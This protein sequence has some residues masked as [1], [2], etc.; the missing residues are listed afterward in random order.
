LQT[1]IKQHFKGDIW[2]WLIAVVGLMM[3]SLPAIYSAS[4]TVA[5]EQEKNYLLAQI[6][7][8]AISLA[9]MYFTHT[10]DYRYYAR[11]SQ[12]ALV[13]AVPLLLYTLFKGDD[14]NEARR[15]ITIPIIKVSFQT[16]DFAKIALIAFVARYL[17]KRQDNIKDFKRTFAPIIFYIGIICLLILPA[18]FST[19]MILFTSCLLLMFIGRV[20]FAQLAALVGVGAVVLAIFFGY[21]IY[22]EKNDLPNFGRLGTWKD[23]V[24]SYAGI[25]KTKNEKESYQTQRANIAIATGGIVGKG[26]GKST[27]RNSLPQAYSDFIYAIIIEEYGLVGGL[28]VMLFYLMF[29]YRV[30]KIVVKAPKAFGALLAV[31]L[32]FNIVFQAVINMAVAVGLFPVTGQTLPFLSV[33]GT[34]LLFTSISVGIILSVSKDIEAQKA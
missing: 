9:A 10:L 24:E 27:Q 18:N 16:S 32:A 19:A 28:V 4:G 6:F 21:L 20:S 2:I 34:S 13:V 14:I 33:G 12:L 25:G 8:I 3:F 29:L 5:F 1:F 17:A 7:F 23:R 30:I 11:I 31:G 15:W 22:T 26:P